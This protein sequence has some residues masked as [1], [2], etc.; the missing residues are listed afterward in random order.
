V[1]TGN[2]AVTA[3]LPRAKL[4]HMMMHVVRT[5]GHEPRVELV[6]GDAAG[7]RRGDGVQGVG[8]GRVAAAGVQTDVRL[9]RG[10]LPHKLEAKPSRGPVYH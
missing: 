1:I 5:S 8:R 2:L 10:V 7:G 9:A 4:H 3:K 6:H